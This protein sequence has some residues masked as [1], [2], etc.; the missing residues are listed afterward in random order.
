MARVTGPTE[1]NAN[2]TIRSR[3]GSEL[4]D[5]GVED[6][7]GEGFEVPMSQ[8]TS[9]LV[10]ASKQKLLCLNHDSSSVAATFKILLTTRDSLEST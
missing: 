4:D 5:Q 7:V 3:I 9:G 1:I 6:K 8:E 10:P 2:G